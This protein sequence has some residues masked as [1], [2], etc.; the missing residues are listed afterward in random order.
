M[1]QLG[2]EGERK[3]KYQFA[4]Q[5]GELRTWHVLQLSETILL[6]TL[7]ILLQALS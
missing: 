4:G 6:T 2:K 5:K 3:R 1:T 7:E